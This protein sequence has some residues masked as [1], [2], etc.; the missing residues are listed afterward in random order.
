[1]G[2]YNLEIQ[3]PRI[4]DPEIIPG[5]LIKKP[6]HNKGPEKTF[7]VCKGVKLSKLTVGT[8]FDKKRKIVLLCK[9][10]RS[11]YKP[12]IFS[13]HQEVPVQPEP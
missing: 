8:L 7:F 6:D 11:G 10:A 9:K 3:E 1:M 12:R 5:Q 2:L 13:H 4:Q